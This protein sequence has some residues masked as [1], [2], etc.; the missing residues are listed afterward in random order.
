MNEEN[1]PVWK[2]IERSP[3]PAPDGWFAARTLARCRREQA[4]PRTWRLL[5]RWILAGAGAF[6]LLTGTTV[7]WMRQ[8]SARQDQAKTYEALEYLADRGTD[9]EL[10]PDSY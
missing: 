1:D 10:W 4:I 5:P 6:L 9:P 3:L 2:L 8:Q 7:M